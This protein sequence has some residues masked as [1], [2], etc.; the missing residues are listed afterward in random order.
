MELLNQQREPL[1][2]FLLLKRRFDEMDKGHQTEIRRAARFNEIAD[3]PAYYRWLQG[4]GSD[5]R[6]QRIAFMLPHVPQQAD[7][8]LLGQQL[9]KE[10]VTEMR[11]FQIIR[12]DPP[13]DLEQLRRLIIYAEPKL[14]WAEFGK[15][16][17]FWGRPAKQRLL[18][19]YFT[20]I[21]QAEKGS[22]T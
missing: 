19:D 1:P 14:D 22:C 12:S 17:F 3:L 10:G 13:R 5:L 16:L 11:L 18:E 2:D 7:R 9:K 8:P 6:M 15:T 4:R 21:K 20:P